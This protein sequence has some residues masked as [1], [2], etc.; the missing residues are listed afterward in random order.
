[1]GSHIFI[2][3][4]EHLQALRMDMMSWFRQLYNAGSAAVGHDQINIINT[5][6]P[7]R[8]HIHCTWFSTVQG[9]GCTS[10][11]CGK[12]M[13][14]SKITTNFKVVSRLKLK[15]LISFYKPGDQFDDYLIFIKLHWITQKFKILMMSCPTPP[16]SQCVCFFLNS[17]CNN[18]VSIFLWTEQPTCFTLCICLTL[19]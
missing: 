1:M 9:T 12:H 5:V 3:A 19:N 11:S 16:A 15:Y 6:K 10:Y 18:H 7:T 13:T 8:I 14:A 2:V 4:I 17:A